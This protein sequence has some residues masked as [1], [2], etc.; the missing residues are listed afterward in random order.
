MFAMGKI[1]RKMLWWIN[2]F[3]IFQ[4]KWRYTICQEF[5]YFLLV[6]NVS[7]RVR[8]QSRGGDRVGVCVCTRMY[9]CECECVCVCVCVRACVCILFMARNQLSLAHNGNVNSP[10]RLSP[11]RGENWLGA[12]CI[13]S[14]SKQ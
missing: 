8:N 11:T 3:C 10:E 5:P 2:L 4:I 6:C 1:Y 7:A 14:K 9:I 12:C 13:F